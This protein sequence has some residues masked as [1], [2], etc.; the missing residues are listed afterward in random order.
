ML[1]FALVALVAFA[2]AQKC[3]PEVECE[4]TVHIGG[5]TYYWD[6]L[7]LCKNGGG[8]YY[9]A[10]TDGH[11]YYA[12]MCGTASTR[13]LPKGWDNVYEYGVAVQLWGAEP[14]CDHTNPSTLTCVEKNTNPAT[15]TCCTRDCQV[16]G[17]GKPSFTLHRSGDVTAGLQVTFTGAVPAADD[18]FWCPWNPSTGSQ[19][20]RTVTY[21]MECD[22]TV[23]GA[24]AVEAIQ[25]A[26]ENCDYHLTFKSQHA[27]PNTHGF[28]Y[29]PSSLSGGWIFI[30]I[31][32]CLAVL[33]FGGGFL[34]TYHTER[35]WAP[36][37]REFW[38]S[39]GQYLSDGIAFITGGCRG[40]G[41]AKAAGSSP[42][43]EIGGGSSSA[44]GAAPPSAYNASS[45]SN[46]AYT[47]L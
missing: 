18:P 10:D 8:D 20:P 45:S 15:P 9:F 36:P 11:D 26:T 13:C 37:N 16:L 42:Y 41:G 3:E 46:T 7:S 4:Y 43:D 38:A 47:D 23:H 30:I 14:D 1:R 33:Y 6:F 28:N 39:F 17:V 5:T 34:Y 21:L 40:L 29:S 12:N 44:G 35:V 2:S 22:P 25:N 27:C 32:I 31:L 19:Y 24:V